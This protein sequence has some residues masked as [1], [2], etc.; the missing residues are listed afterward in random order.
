MGVL[1]LTFLHDVVHR[2]APLHSTKKVREDSIGPASQVCSVGLQTRCNTDVGVGWCRKSPRL[3]GGPSA[4]LGSPRYSRVRKLGGQHQSPAPHLRTRSHWRVPAKRVIAI[5]LILLL[6]S[7][8]SSAAAGL[9]WQSITGGRMARLAVPATGHAGFTLMAGPQMGIHF[10]NMLD[11]RLVMKNNN[12]ME[13]AGV[14]LG[15]FDGD[16]W[17]D[18]YFCAI[19]GTNALYRNLGN[20]T[21]EDVTARAG[22]GGSGWHSTGAVFADIDGDG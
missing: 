3:L 17:C 6:T 18:I 4:G 15:D 10:T 21:F 20:W 13:G 12:F 8:W 16:G 9:E 22:V 19:D 11:D 14:T 2:S 7:S 5:G 1:K